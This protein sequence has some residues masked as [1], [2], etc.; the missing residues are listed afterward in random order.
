[1]D[2]KTIAAVAMALLSAGC[3]DS[4]RTGSTTAALGKGVA[5]HGYVPYSKDTI[6]VRLKN[7]STGTYSSFTTITSSTFPS[8]DCSGV[9]WYEYSKT[10]NLPQDYKTYHYGN[11]AD[12][13]ISAYLRLSSAKGGDIA[14]FDA[15]A[16]TCAQQYCAG[17]DVMSNCQDS[18]SPL[19]TL[20]IPCG[21]KGNFC[22]I[23]GGANT[24]AD[25][26]S[27]S[28][29]NYKGQCEASSWLTSDADYIYDYAYPKYKDHD[30]TEAVNG[31][32]RDA[33]FWYFTQQHALVKVPVTTGLDQNLKDNSE[34]VF[35]GDENNETM[36]VWIP[37]NYV[38]M[39]DCDAYNGKLYI[40]VESDGKKRPALYVEVNASDLSLSSSGTNPDSTVV[41]APWVAINPKNGFLYTS[42]FN[43]NFI[44]VYSI[45]HQG[46]QLVLTEQSHVNLLDQQGKP[47]TVYRIQG[48]AFSPS[49]KLYLSSD[50]APDFGKPA[51]DHGIYG[52]QIGPNT[53]R[54]QVHKVTPVN[55]ADVVGANSGDEIQ[56]I[57]IWDMTWP[58]GNRNQIHHVT[59]DKDL[60]TDEITFRHYALSDPSK[61]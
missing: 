25:L 5:I 33:N 1:M 17:L 47:L 8:P 51:I 34:V 10:I 38:H 48:G 40:P 3:V 24:T 14:T 30:W 4:P 61:L 31:V 22:C 45:S 42:D 29:C 35:V 19:L 60:G 53:A 43:T 11:P 44:R 50:D 16:D 56:G 58:S 18:A 21:T 20:R 32:A 2:R 7:V 9:N 49:G 23:K 36:P 55:Y 54:L 6:D 27:G 15:N 59:L 57:T 41:D 12:Q 52:F 39:G 37:T 26:C 13:N 28:L 46:Q